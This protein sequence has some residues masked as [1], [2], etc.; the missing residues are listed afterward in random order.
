MVNKNKIEKRKSEGIGR[1]DFIWKSAVACCMAN[2]P[3]A[4]SILSQEE[5]KKL[6]GYSGKEKMILIPIENWKY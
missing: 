1:R 4:A 5:K 2:I 3:F 6:K